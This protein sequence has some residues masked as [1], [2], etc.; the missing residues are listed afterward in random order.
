ML[1]TGISKAKNHRQSVSLYGRSSQ[2]NNILMKITD[3]STESTV[4]MKNTE[5][6]HHSTNLDSD[7]YL[8][9]FP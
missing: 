4:N 8:F 3:C 5:F 7:F 9:L 6:E 2:P 1:E